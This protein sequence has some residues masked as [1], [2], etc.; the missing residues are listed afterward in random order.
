MFAASLRS[1]AAV[2]VRAAAC[3]PR[4]FGSTVQGRRMSSG[5]LYSKQHDWIEISGSTAK[6]GISNHAAS[7]LGDIVFVE[8]PETGTEFAQGDTIATVESV[9]ACSEVEAV[10]SGT[11]TEVNSSVSDEPGIVNK[12]AEGAG[13]LYK[14]DVGSKPKIGH[15]MSSE[16]YAEFTEN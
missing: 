5:R 16:E 3:M 11:V 1:C 6:A 4:A 14:M 10:V 2:Q 9:K 13:W 7:E 15:L 8:M 12:E